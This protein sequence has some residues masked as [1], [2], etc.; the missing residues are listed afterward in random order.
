MK[1]QKLKV[2]HIGFGILL[3]LC[4]LCHTSC[5]KYDN[6]DRLKGNTYTYWNGYTGRYQ[7]RM[8]YEF[9]RD[10]SVINAAN[11]ADISTTSEHLRYTLSGELLTIYHDNST[12]WKKEARNAVFERGT[13]T[14]TSIIIDGDEYVLR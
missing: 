3:M 4:T 9:K 8:S 5:K 7:I 6:D 11:I 14:G 12:Y 10:G 2:S 1:K 13:F